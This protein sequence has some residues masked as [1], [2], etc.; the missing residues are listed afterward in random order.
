MC[1][2]I[3][4]Q[5]GALIFVTPIWRGAPIFVTRVRGGASIFVTWVRGCTEICHG[6]TRNLNPLHIIVEHFL[7][8]KMCLSFTNLSMYVPT[9]ITNQFFSR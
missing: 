4:I 7:S 8:I 1:R 2:G 5:G 9:G 6:E 3:K